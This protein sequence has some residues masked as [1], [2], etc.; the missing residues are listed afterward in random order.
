VLP[1]EESEALLSLLF[2]DQDSKEQLIRPLVQKV[3][4]VPSA[5]T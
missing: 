1:Q 3:K 4:M 2:L 5:L